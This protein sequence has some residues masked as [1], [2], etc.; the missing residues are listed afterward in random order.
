LGQAAE[1]APHRQKFRELQAAQLRQSIAQTGRYDD[2]NSTRQD[3]ANFYLAA[4]RLYLERGD[5][6]AAEQHAE[7]ALE[8]APDNEQGRAELAQLYAK[9]GRLQ[10]AVDVLLPLKK[11]RARD[12]GFW[13]RL[14]QLYAQLQAFEEADEALRRIVELAPD[15][16][17]GYAAQA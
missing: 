9:T 2:L 8:L 1:A 3:M 10:E 6:A 15:Q 12:A 5:E 14:A 16:A 7:R 11:T 13:Q 17:P 4:G